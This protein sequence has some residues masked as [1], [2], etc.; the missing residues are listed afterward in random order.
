[1]FFSHLIVNFFVCR[2]NFRGDPR[3]NL[4]VEWVREMSSLL[5]VPP[6]KYWKNED[7][8]MAFLLLFISLV[9]EAG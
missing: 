2:V 6:C 8:E 7:G 4:A 1:M 9:M 5:S 3:V